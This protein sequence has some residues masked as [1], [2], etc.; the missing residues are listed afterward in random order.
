VLDLPSCLSMNRP[1][2]PAK[3]EPK[4]R[5]SDVLLVVVVILVLAFALWVFYTGRFDS[6]VGSFLD[7]VWNSIQGMLRPIFRR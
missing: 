4:M 2:R 5:K 6:L 3:E 7:Q 1:G